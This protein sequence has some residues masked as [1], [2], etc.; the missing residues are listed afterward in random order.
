MAEPPILLPLQVMARPLVLRF[1]YHF[2]GNRPTNRLDK[3]EYFL[4]NVLDILETHNDFL[5]EFLQPVLDRRSQHNA[6]NFD[7]PHTDATS[8]FITSLL[9]MAREKL[10]ALLPQ[11]KDNSN[12]LSHLMNELMKFDDTLRDSWGYTPNPSALESWKGLTWEVLVTYSYFEAWL[13]DEKTFALSR[14]KTIIAADDS[15]DIDYDSL[16]AS[17]TKPSKGAIRVN[18]LLE[19]ITDRYRPLFS[20]SQKL[21]FLIDIQLEIFDQYHNRLSDSLENYLVRTSTLGRATMTTDQNSQTID[22]SGIVGLERLCRVFGSAAYLEDKMSDWSEDIFFLELWDELLDRSKQNSRTGRSVARDLST[23]QI[24]AKTSASVASGTEDAD[25]SNNG[26]LFDE[27]ASA[28]RHL[29]LRSETILKETLDANIRSAFKLYSKV[30]SWSSLSVPSSSPTPSPE[31]DPVLH[32]LTTQLSFLVTVLSPVHLRRVARQVC[33]ALQDFLLDRVL[34]R[35]T[36]SAAG[37]AQL[38]AD[39]SALCAVIGRSINIGE[40]TAGMMRKLLEGV[41]LVSLPIRAAGQRKGVRVQKI[42]EDEGEEDAWDLDDGEAGTDESGND[43]EPEVDADGEKVWGLWEVEKRLFKSNEEAREVL[44]EMGVDFLDV[45]EAR[46][47]LKRR[48]EVGS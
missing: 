6:H 41:R 12:L 15:G 2:S 34:N 5:V 24:A 23:A 39:V 10:L 46:N 30:A 44:S 14:Y 18:D 36:F 31:L 26:A 32:V 8:A 19:T 11:I 47:L 48:V 13:Q 33:G 27:T 1:K 35:N 29:R 16:E 3:P 43:G 17:S 21:R 40:E 38:S 37:A 25:E 42:V 4:S 28:Y 45:N 7:L 22:L 20:F 9:P